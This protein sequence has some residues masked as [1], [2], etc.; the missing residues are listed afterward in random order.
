[1]SIIFASPE[2]SL[3]EY[4]ILSQILD[5]SVAAK[6]DERSDGILTMIQDN[7]QVQLVEFHSIHNPTRA[8]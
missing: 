3:N 4:R 2:S 6:L 7:Y 5:A 8:N 1:M